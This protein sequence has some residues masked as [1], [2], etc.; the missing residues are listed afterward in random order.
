MLL[1]ILAGLLV[2]AVM[3]ILLDLYN[4]AEVPKQHQRWQSQ[5]PA[6]G[7]EAFN[8]F[9]V[10]QVTDLHISKFLHPER[11]SDFEK[12]CMESIDFIKP[13]LILVTGDLTDS[14]TKD[15][16]GSDQFEMEWQMYQ[17]ILKKSKAMEKW[18]W[19]DIRG[20]HDSFNIPD[21][22][23]FRNYYRKYSALRKEGSFHYIH[24]TPFGNYSF[25][26]VDATLTPG[27]KRPFNFFGILN[28]RQMD[29]LSLLEKESQH[30]NQSVW[31]GHYPTSTIMSSSPGIRAVMSSA[32]AYLC[33][34]LHTLG[35]ILPTIYSRH[36]QGTLELELGDWMDNRRYRI[37]AFDHDLLSFADVKYD[38]WPV[39][40]ITNPKSALYRS[41]AH[42]P[43]GRMKYSTHIRILAF[44][45]FPITSVDVELDGVF[46][47]RA[48][49]V[50]GPL[51]VL[52]WNPSNYSTGL[53]RI[54]A[55]VQ[56]ASG[57]I[58]T[59]SHMF[60]LDDNVS[61]SFD[62]LS[63]LILL[64]DLYI[65]GQVFFV[66]MVVVQVGVLVAFRY[67]RK[68]ALKRNPGFVS[69]TFFSFHVMSK[70]NCVYYPLLLLSLYTAVGDFLW[71]TNKSSNLSSS[72]TCLICGPTKIPSLILASIILGNICLR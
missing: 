18:K 27:P 2:A 51:Y 31:F 19:L 23:S 41:S 6:P 7:A 64:S 49:H 67:L 21:L 5:F 59:R 13:S 1:K 60:T 28:K 38:E 70:T 16:L 39:V 9:W 56:D 61:L 42:E 63:S 32:T 8:V 45:R 71:S 26:C 12:F 48:V 69:L 40:L 54:E 62:F 53:H 58:N 14:K 65:M 20:N 52:K 3:A 34:H 50:S 24:R 10:V 29:E 68:P 66:L 11:A 55:L 33:G 72:M 4:T 47:E 57:K 36:S 30:S 44:S 43:L 25:I 17:T 15:K 46:S 35:G 37:L 22:Q